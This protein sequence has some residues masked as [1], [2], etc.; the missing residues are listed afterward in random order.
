MSLALRLNLISLCFALTVTAVLVA[1]GALLLY[2]QH[3]TEATHLAEDAGRELAQRAEQ[4]LT[5]GLPLPDL[6]GFEEQCQAVLPRNGLLQSAMV[7]D[8]KRQ[9]L[10]ASLGGSPAWPA[11]LGEGRS[12]VPDGWVLQPIRLEGQA[13]AGWV[14]VATDPQRV[15]TNTLQQVGWLV[16]LAGLL[17]MGGLLLQQFLFWRTVGRPLGELVTAA[18]NIDRNTP[19]TPALP[20]G[21]DDIG[22]VHA[23]L[24]R[25]V[26]RLQ[27]AQAQLQADNAHLESMVAERT[28]RLSEANAALQRDLNRREEL[29]AELRRL[30][31]TDALTGLASRGFFRG[32]AAPRMESARRQRQTLTFY[33]FDLDHF[34]PINDTLGHAVG[35][36]VLYQ[37]SQRVRQMA[38]G[39]DVLARLG[40]DEFG[41]MCEGGQGLDESGNLGQRLVDLFKAPFV[42][43]GHVLEVGVS[44]GVAS[45][46]QHGPD[47][48]TVLSAADAAMYTAKQRGGGL[49]H[50]PLSW[51]PHVVTVNQGHSAQG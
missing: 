25:L 1:V 11:E 10:F 9:G 15:L 44:V 32:H 24:R 2:Q 19:A 43:E 42:A 50:A 18:D 49:A 8:A 13:T 4:L 35:D 30:A 37:A 27:A 7:F 36:Q 41:L 28:Q 3:K 48:A 47:L 40:G 16:G 45:L 20:L 31:N 39:S 33:L 5:L 46:P 38:R 23:A 34:K 29:E 22:R 21:D 14:V 6:L 12:T 26:G 51:T 17:F